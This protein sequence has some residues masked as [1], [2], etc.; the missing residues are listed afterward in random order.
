MMDMKVADTHM[1]KVLERHGSAKFEAKEEEH[2][3]SIMKRLGKRLK[4]KATKKSKR[5][6]TNSDIEEEKNLKT[7]LQI[8]PDEECEI[9]YEVLD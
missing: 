6:K 5:E 8:V 9:D 4:M 7:F 2:E 3:G 1:E